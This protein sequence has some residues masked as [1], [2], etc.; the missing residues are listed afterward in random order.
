MQEYK[1]LSIEVGKKVLDRQAESLANLQGK[2]NTEKSK[3]GR[4]QTTYKET[5]VRTPVDPILRRSSSEG[6]FS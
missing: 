1:K 6:E 3:G 5:T 4:Q 2:L